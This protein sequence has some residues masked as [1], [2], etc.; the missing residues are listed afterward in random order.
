MWHTPRDAVMPL[1]FK[2]NE[3]DHEVCEPHFASCPYKVEYSRRLQEK[4]KRKAAENGPMSPD[5]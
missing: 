2:N 1:D 4:E 3:H 5:A